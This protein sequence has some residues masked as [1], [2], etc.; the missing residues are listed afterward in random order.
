MTGRPETGREFHER[1]NIVCLVPALPSS[2]EAV[3]EFHRW[4]MQ[5]KQALEYII[6]FQLP[7]ATG[8]WWN[9]AANLVPIL[10]SQNQV[11]YRRHLWKDL[12]KKL[13]EKAVGEYG[14]G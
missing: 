4:D 3:R 13:L 5:K 1:G 6:H 11:R 12:Y 14:D 7:I 9:L 10:N 8:K 2:S